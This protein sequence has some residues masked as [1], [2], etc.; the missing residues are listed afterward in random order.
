MLEYPLNRTFP[1][2]E[3]EA[4]V[5]QAVAG[6]LDLDPGEVKLESSLQ[7]DLGAES[8]DYLDIA[9]QLERKYRIEFPRVDLLERAGR[10]FGEDRLVKDGIVSDLGL[11]LLRQAMPEI[12]PERLQPGLRAVQVPAL[13]NVQTFA[14]VLDRLVYAKEQ[15][16]RTCKECGG[17]LVESEVL[18]E[19]VCSGCGKSFPMPSGDDV[20]YEDLVHL[21]EEAGVQEQPS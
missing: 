20:L 10:Y 17:T 9:F 5:I 14:R 11:R 18:P 4:S 19:F 2:Q 7:A 15:M 21:G 12:A 1:R 13:F 16:P 6:A 3:L 8:L